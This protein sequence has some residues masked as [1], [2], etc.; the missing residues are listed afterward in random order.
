MNWTEHPGSLKTLGDRNFALGINKLVLH[1]FT[2]NPWMDKKPGMTLDGVGLY[3]QRDQTWFKQSKA[4]IEYLTRC[5]ALLQ[6][7]KPVV[8]IAVFT[9]EEVPRRS[10]LPDRLV[11]TLPGIFGNQKVAAEKKR[12][13]NV[14][15]PQRQIPD[16]VTHS[17]NMAD[18]ENWID[19]LNG[20]AY[21]SFNPDVLLQ[22]TVKNGR[23]VTPSGASYKI[24]VFPDKHQLNPNNKLMSVAVAKKLFQLVKDGATVIMGKEY[25][26]GIGLKDK[27]AEVKSLRK[28]LMKQ[29]DKK[30]KVV[31]SP[32]VDSSFAR[33]GLEK[34]VE[35]VDND[36]S[37][38]WTHRQTA[39]ED[40]YF[41]SNQAD[42]GQI[43]DLSLRV[44][45]KEPELFDAVTGKQH[46]TVLWNV[47]KNRTHATVV[48]DANES[49][50]IVFRTAALDHKR[51]LYGKTGSFN[52]IDMSTGWMVKFD[53]KYGGPKQPVSL[54]R[55]ESWTESSDTAIKYYSGTAVYTKSF[56][57]TKE[58]EDKE[59]FL[60]IEE[61]N[62]LAT[63]KVNGID[64]GT[65][66]TYPYK[67]EISKAL[68]IG[69]N[70]I[71]IIVSNTWRNRLIG[72]NLLPPEKRITSTT[73]PFRLK[74]KPL[75]PAGL[76]GSVKI[77]IR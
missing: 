64:C 40:I 47:E 19:P 49:V 53:E 27:D 4:W 75:Q 61:M 32:Y 18:P 31:L 22:M 63:I 46:E 26:Q 9:G 28:E 67:I 29:G 44:Y 66:W 45:G 16:G 33:L 41:I 1:V 10:I 71:E 62:G 65:V 77:F 5:Q 7:G 24:L 34:D 2:H 74:D 70:K 8:D 23:V 38:A 57:F 48:L 20:Y 36:N 3:F 11:S 76:I 25:Q 68:G 42:E 21:D 51:P 13:E 72:D 35:I 73:A 55:L 39:N 52:T 14:G 12:V 58:K 17:A 30:G 37:I 69:N 54:D 50:F 56:A 43:V 6:L 59:A 15:Q 60:Q